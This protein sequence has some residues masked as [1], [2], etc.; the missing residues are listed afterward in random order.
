MHRCYSYVGHQGGEQPVS[1][2][3]GCLFQGTVA[4]ELLHVIGFYHEHSRPDRDDY[5]II[6]PDNVMP[7]YL[8]S[9]RKLATD[10]TR[11]LTPFDYDSISMYG[12]SAFA[13][14]PRLTTM[15]AKNRRRLLDIYN[16]PGLT[17]SDAT[18]INILYNCTIKRRP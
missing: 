13:R 9:F 14:S 2:G 12:S 15:V 7:E 17:K 16:K 10:E 3:Y 8:S 5:V 1:L 6:Y 11:L 18:R 4:H